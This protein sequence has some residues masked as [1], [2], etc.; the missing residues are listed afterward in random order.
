MP[1]VTASCGA[2]ADRVY[3]REELDEMDKQRNYKTINDK[4]AEAELD[5]F[6]RDKNKFQRR[7]SL[8]ELRRTLRAAQDEI[9]TK[10]T[11]SIATEYY[12][13]KEF[14]LL[15][16]R[17]QFRAAGKSVP[18]IYDMSFDERRKREAVFVLKILNFKPSRTIHTPSV[19]IGKA[20]AI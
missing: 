13:R 17:N 12:R 3:R 9:L 11:V 14:Y 4:Y 5:I 16:R 15:Q 20:A 7:T 10:G 19:A 2:N 1:R 6:G 18:K 8:I